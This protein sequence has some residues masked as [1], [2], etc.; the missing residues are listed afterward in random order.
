MRIIIGNIEV[1]T[2]DDSIQWDALLQNAVNHIKENE[3]SFTEGQQFNDI[4]EVLNV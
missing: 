1:N 2:S 3:S 4:E